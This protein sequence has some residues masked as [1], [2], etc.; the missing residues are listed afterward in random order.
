MRKFLFL[1]ENIGE[2]REDITLISGKWNL[3]AISF[4][5]FCIRLTDDYA[6]L[7]RSGVS[8]MEQTNPAFSQK[9]TC[10]PRIITS[11]WKHI[12]CASWLLLCG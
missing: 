4:I 8:L 9:L 2:I 1:L 10:A 7:K 11:R 6:Y 12:Q 5:R 3:L